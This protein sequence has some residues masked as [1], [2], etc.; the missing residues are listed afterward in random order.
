MRGV[1]VRFYLNDESLI[2]KARVKRYIDQEKIS[3]FTFK[4]GS[5][6][7]IK[8]LNKQ[9]KKNRDRRVQILGFDKR[10]EKDLERVKVKYLDTNRNG[11][12]E[13]DDLDVLD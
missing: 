4:I 1:D 8:P 6:L 5:E 13:I 2:E 10:N 3:E 9:K 7:V 11:F 12:V